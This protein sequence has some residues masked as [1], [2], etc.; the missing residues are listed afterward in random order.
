MSNLGQP[1][2]C[3]QQGYTHSHNETAFVVFFSVSEARLN[4]HVQP[5]YNYGWIINNQ[6]VM[7]DS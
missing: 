4:F 2:H 3:C 6:P 5:K 1:S 7:Y